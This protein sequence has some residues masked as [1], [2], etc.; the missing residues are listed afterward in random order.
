MNF[1]TSL[2]KSIHHYISNIT[3][4][5]IR[6]HK[7]HN[8]SL[9]PKLGFCLFFHIYF[10]HN[11]LKYSNY[12]NRRSNV[13]LYKHCIGNDPYV[14]PHQINN[15]LTLTVRNKVRNYLECFKYSGNSPMRIRRS[16]VI[17]ILFLNSVLLPVS[18]SI[19]DCLKS[20]HHRIH[21]MQFY[22]S[23]FCS[24]KSLKLHGRLLT[25]RTKNDQLHTVYRCFLGFQSTLHNLEYS[26]VQRISCLSNSSRFCIQSTKYHYYCILSNL[27]QY[28]SNKNYLN[29]G[30]YYLYNFDK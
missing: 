1:Q 20:N 21:C 14:L 5:F 30:S 7:Q 26:C 22:L 25:V 13:L 19:Q 16:P 3:I 6:K 15:T 27:E 17:L 2:L 9:F 18:L 29:L 23:N 4:L 12:L 8:H 10:L 28:H 24:V 11:F